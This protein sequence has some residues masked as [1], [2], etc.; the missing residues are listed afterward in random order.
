[1]IAVY[2]NGIGVQGPGLSHWPQT[3][4]IL[5]GERPYG[6]APT[7]LA[8]PAMLPPVERRRAGGP[9]KLAIAVALEACER[10]GADPARLTAVFSSSGG[11]GHNCH[12]LCEA[13]ALADR[14]IS[15]TRF[16]NS[17]H[18]AAA[19]YWSI[20]TGAMAPANV[21]CAHDASFAA[22]LLEACAQVR[23]SQQPL[24]L[25]AYDTAYPEPIHSK[26]SLPDAFG[27]A[28]VLAP[29]REACSL[30]RLAVA[31]TAER[32]D[33][34]PETSLESLRTAIPAARSLPLL[35]RIGLPDPGRAVLDYLGETRLRVDVDQCRPA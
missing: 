14:E 2:V 11:D 12:E 8:P 3:A 19:G 18:N 15:P 29:G 28:M 34:L 20:A 21:L 5:R 10:A 6:H 9:V 13:L 30:A 23:T 17:V 1:M 16:A 31:L 7:V 35:R 22:G 26:R 32:P 4:A 27:V 24:L 33:D 25:V